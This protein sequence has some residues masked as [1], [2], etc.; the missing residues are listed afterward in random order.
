MTRVSM[1]NKT[2]KQKQ[3]HIKNFQ[4]ANKQKCQCSTIK[5]LTRVSLLATL[6]QL[7]QAEGKIVTRPTLTAVQEQ[8]QRSRPGV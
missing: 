4:T 1:T 3:L 7:S 5:T 6:L 8:T 2:P